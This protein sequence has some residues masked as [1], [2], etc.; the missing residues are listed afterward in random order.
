MANVVVRRSRA[1][2]TR[3]VRHATSIAL[4]V[5]GLVL[6]LVGWQIAGTAQPVLLATPGRSWEALV[7]LAQSGEL[8]QAF[9]ESGVIFV[10]GLVLATIVGIGYGILIS[11][12]RWLRD[13][14]SWLIFALQAVPIIALA[15]LIVVAVGFGT[16]AKS[17]V[18]FLSAVFPILINT[19]E[20]AKHAPG[21]LLDVTRIFR[22][23]EWRVWADL[24][25]PHTLPYAMTGIRQGIAMAFVGTMVAEFFLNA[26]G[27]GG[28]MLGASARFDTALV[29]AL[30]VLIAVVAVILIGFG[31]LLERAA[32]RWKPEEVSE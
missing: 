2:R 12:V 24:L 25:L 22:S 21:P 6:G 11:R 28:L 20:G 31:R 15:P 26:N 16:G 19:M 14:T 9:L 5:L 4:A 27:I 29:L 10:I 30:S 17:L 7:A 8:G 1:G 23:R 18:V 13:A 32:G 3:F